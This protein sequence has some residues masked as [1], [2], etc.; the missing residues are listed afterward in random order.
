MADPFRLRVLQ[1]LTSAL[2]EIT[3]ANGY[4]H[5]LSTNV[6]RGRTL[7]GEGDPLPL[8]SVLEAPQPPDELLLSAD[9][10]VAAGDWRL[11]V[12]GFVQDD[13]ENPTDPAYRLEADVRLR[14]AR[15]RKR[16]VDGFPAP[17]GFPDG[18]GGAVT[19][20]TIG[21]PVVRPA[22]DEVSSN[23]FFWIPVTL[24]LVEDDDAPFS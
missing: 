1:A 5:D 14:L 13:P 12:Q 15:E 3:L 7:Y 16:R 10:A 4:S 17:L 2:R 11:I 23:A 6:F 22:D 20:L 18:E 19:A 24:R 9:A 21:R 8:V